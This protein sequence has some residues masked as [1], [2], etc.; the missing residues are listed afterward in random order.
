MIAPQLKFLFFILLAASMLLAACTPRLISPSPPKPTLPSKTPVLISKPVASKS[1][2]A[3][4]KRLSAAEF[5]LFNDDNHYR[6]LAQSIA[7]SLSYLKQLP[8][9]HLFYFG[10]DRYSTA[11]LI[12]SLAYFE[13]IIS[14]Y[15]SPNALN[16]VIA[17]HYLVYASSGRPVEKDVLFTGYYEPLLSGSMHQS[18]QY[19]IP[20]H[21]RPSDLVEIDLGA[22]AA[23]LKGRKI[24]G[25]YTGQSV[26]PY[27]TRGQIRHLSNF[28]QT[29]PPIAWLR[30]EVDLF[31]LQIQ[32][33]GRIE[34]ENGQ[35]INILYD[36]HNGRP[37]YSIGR[38]LIDQGRIPADKMSMQ[39]IRAYL[40]RHR[41]VAASILDH[42]SR[43]IF[44]KKAEQGPIGALGQLLT[45]MRSLAV[46][47]K[48]M[49][50]AALAFISLPLPVVNP[51]G[52][53]EKWSRY[54]GFAL[55]QDAGSAILGP[56]RIDLFMGHGL[57]A[58]TAASHLKNSGVLYFLV[59]NPEAMPSMDARVETD[60]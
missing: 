60:G 14:T 9:D 28:N 45:P 7:I 57:E 48:V 47:R 1:S 46:D 37:Y 38:L 22:F 11:H 34:L 40:A 24:V 12:Q 49:P 10:N 33:S 18:A 20:V 54:S 39:A 23:D 29:A 35:Q 15:P 19:P 59:L 8:A 26:K 13:H 21:S 53:I 56:G 5:P 43:Y 36:G 32:G 50:S 44:F 55:A 30:D 42:N 31:N 2:E 17:T 41:D 25:Q 51:I 27:P 16:Q 58:E 4:L 6:D 52:R 3:S